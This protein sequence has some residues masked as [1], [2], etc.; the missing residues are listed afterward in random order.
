MLEVSANLCYFADHTNQQTTGNNIMTYQY[1]TITGTYNG[2]PEVLWGSYDKNECK[3]EIESERDGWKAEG[4]KAI[5]IVT[6]NTS[7]APDPTVYDKKQ[8]KRILSS[9]TL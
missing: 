1:H 4:L 8:L 3:Y 9:A 6:S 7:E 5:K 2:A